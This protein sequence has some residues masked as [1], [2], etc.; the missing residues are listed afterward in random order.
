MAIPVR[1][2][3][4]LGA[5]T[6]MVLA[7]FHAA[8]GVRPYGCELSRWAHARIPQRYRER[9]RC[10]DMR[11]YVPSLERSHS[12]FDLVFANSLVYLHPHEIDGFLDSCGRI[13]SHFHF[14]SST[15]EDKAEHDPYRVT[16]RP[17]TWWRRRFVGAGFEPT[18]SPY[19]WRSTRRG[20]W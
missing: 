17:R 12:E 20:R 6:G 9:I 5:A 15:T 8:W 4:V 14:W 13:A 10:S 1:S 16:L 18:R 3:L 19:L 11:G 7:D 2:V